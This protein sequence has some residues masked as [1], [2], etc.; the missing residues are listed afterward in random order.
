MN[1]NPQH[2]DEFLTQ[3]RKTPRP[4][5]ARK[6]YEKISQEHG[7]TM[8]HVAEM[9]SFSLNGTR[10]RPRS[11]WDQPAALLAALIALV[12]VGSLVLWFNRPS[13]D[14][15]PA[16]TLPASQ[17][18]TPNNA[19]QLTKLAR[20]GDGS[21]NDVAWSPDGKVLALPGSVGVW[22]YNADDLS[23]PIDMIP[24]ESGSMQTVQ[25]LPD[26]QHLLI[27]DF[28]S[29]RLWDM[30]T[31]TLT[32]V[33]FSM[34]NYA[35]FDISPGG[36]LVAAGDYQGNLRIYDLQ[37][38]EVK[39]QWT[40]N[41]VY[42]PM[43]E[44]TFSPDSTR[45]AFTG[46]QMPV[47]MLQDPTGQWDHF[48]GEPSVFKPA[49][50]FEAG[51][52]SVHFNRDGSLL[53]ARVGA[54]IY[55]WDTAT[56]EV[57][58]VLN[59]AP[60]VED[61]PTPVPL[62]PGSNPYG[63]VSGGG[64]GGGS[65]GGNGDLTFSPDGKRLVTTDVAVQM[66]D[67]ATGE[68][69]TILAAQPNSYISA[70][71]FNAD[72]TQLAQVDPANSVVR[73]LDVETG[74]EIT[75]LDQY[76][77][78]NIVDVDFNADAS[79]LAAYTDDSLIHVW[80]ISD[81]SAIK[82]PLRLTNAV[83]ETVYGF[84][85]LAFNPQD[86]QVLAALT[87]GGVL[88]WNVE[89]GQPDSLWANPTGNGQGISYMGVLAYSPDGKLVAS[90][91]RDGAEIFIWDAASG[92]TTLQ[93][94]GNQVVRDAVFSPNST[95]LAVATDANPNI[96]PPADGSQS[97]TYS[98]DIWDV[99]EQEVIATL[100]QQ[101]A[102]VLRLAYSPD[103][104]LLATA[105]GDSMVQLWDAE[106]G[107]SVRTIEQGNGVGTLAFSPDGRLLVTAE[108]ASD[109]QRNVLR[110]WDINSPD[111]EPL[112]TLDDPLGTND[113]TFSTDGKLFAAASP[114]GTIDLWGVK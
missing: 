77:I 39:T 25:F 74:A 90:S 29:V 48:E 94:Q 51:T 101:S 59:T 81:L 54:D 2:D 23:Q 57:V 65:K 9:K 17:V 40:L 97:N 55:L 50:Q 7:E 46:S 37:T 75:R 100:G 103:G 32:T 109:D 76:S 28:Y 102:P 110:V 21:V 27:R 95:R 88:P 63:A 60:P 83:P 92:Q 56:A 44:V 113:L 84:Q 62:P 34:D 12:L 49:T 41:Y 15:A 31:R 36:R 19:T 106:T 18:I 3:F 68:R 45:L 80:D 24:N 53:T 89:T 33:P 99:S 96:I 91:S 86:K 1:N 79:R 30:G 6:L 20:L 71:A 61:Q 114:N 112:A 107:Q 104:K 4:E 70:I 35:G 73:I 67:I 69:R 22:L 47:L 64:G 72:W 38:G 85:R 93:I 8:F 11:R 105:G 58:K 78:R 5:F 111:S 66:W 26:S 10:S 14:I 52:W 98:V 87:G 13:P 43:T 16:A 42:T 108:F 82:A